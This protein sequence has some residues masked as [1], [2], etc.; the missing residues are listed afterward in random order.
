MTRM[1]LQYFRL[2]QEQF[3]ITDNSYF[4]KKVDGF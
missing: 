4:E 3:K 1:G 2:H